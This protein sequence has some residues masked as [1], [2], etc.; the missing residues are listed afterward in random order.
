[1]KELAVAQRFLLAA[2]RLSQAEVVRAMEAL[3]QEIFRLSSILADRIQVE[4]RK[5]QPPD[6][7]EMFRKRILTLGPAFLEV[8]EAKHLK[9]SLAIQLGWQATLVWWCYEVIEAWVVEDLGIREVNGELKEIYRGIKA[10]NDQAVAGRWRSLAHGVLDEIPS[11][12]SEGLSGDL[13]RPLAALP[14]LC[15]YIFNKEPYQELCKA[16]EQRIGRLTDKCLKFRKMIGEG[17]TSTDIR[18]YFVRSGDNYNP[19]YAELECEDE[20]DGSPK[21]QAGVI[22]CS[23]GLGLYCTRTTPSADNQFVEHREP[24]LKPKIIL[25]ETLKEIIA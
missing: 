6:R 20:K 18:P 21:E 7:L 24:I 15:G 25:L 5:L 10:T 12:I 16:F 17:I 22:A 8:V 23:L 4:E 11:E 2:D 19:D 13:I 14:V 1:M 3:N 9:D